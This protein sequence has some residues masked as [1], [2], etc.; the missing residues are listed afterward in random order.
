[1]NE[2]DLPAAPPLPSDVRERALRTVLDGIDAPAVPARRAPFLA[3][4][5]AVVVAIA[6]TTAT[7][8][9]GLGPD[10]PAGL[11]R[12]PPAAGSGG[13]DPHPRPDRRPVCRCRAAPAQR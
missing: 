9:S 1:M 12:L 2:L 7:A 10:D 11:D 13:G 6:L 4:A 8:I 5:A 3:A